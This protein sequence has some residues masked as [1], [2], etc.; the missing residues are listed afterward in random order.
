M[1]WLYFRFRMQRTNGKVTS[2]KKRGTGSTII[3]ILFMPLMEVQN[4]VATDPI[5][6][7]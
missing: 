2:I 6:M 4:D 5:W 3:Q 7:W 1:T